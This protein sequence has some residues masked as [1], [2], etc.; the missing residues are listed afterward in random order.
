MAL[1]RLFITFDEQ[2]V[3]CRPVD[4]EMV[5]SELTDGRH[6][7]AID[8]DVPAWLIPSRTPGNSHLYI[9]VP[10]TWRQYRRIL[11]ALRDGGVIE[12]GYYAMAVKKGRTSLRRPRG[13]DRWLTPE[14]ETAG[15][16]Y[17]AVTDA[18]AELRRALKVDVPESADARSAR[19]ED[20]NRNVEAVRGYSGRQADE[21]QAKVW[22]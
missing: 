4:G 18:M 16:L 17:G 9:D 6:A 8:L 5:T 19:Y 15:A 7:P 13:Y 14:S 2:D 11:K 12:P 21:P 1:K 10:M 3:P 20:V 22:F